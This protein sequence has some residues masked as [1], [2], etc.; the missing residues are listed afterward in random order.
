MK[1]LDPAGLNRL[2]KHVQSLRDKHFPHRVA[3]PN[4]DF[5]NNLHHEWL[6]Q[7]MGQEGIRF[8]AGDPFDIN[9]ITVRKNA[10]WTLNGDSLNFAQADDAVL[11]KL[12]WC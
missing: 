11:F 3:L 6:V 4:E 8:A 5:F 10:R 1:S 12:T 2:S 7:H 9:C